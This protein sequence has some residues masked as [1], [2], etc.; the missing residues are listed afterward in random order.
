MKKQILCSAMIALLIGSTSTSVGSIF[1]NAD[2][3]ATTKIETTKQAIVDDELST[4][5]TLSKPIFNIDQSTYL[6]AVKYDWY[7]VGGDRV[8][9]SRYTN[10]N[11]AEMGNSPHY[12]EYQFPFQSAHDSATLCVP[13]DYYYKS[14][15]TATKTMSYSYSTSEHTATVTDKNGN[16]YTA[17][18][19]G[20]DCQL[21][22]VYS[23]EEFALHGTIPT[24]FDE[25]HYVWYHRANKNYKV[26]ATLRYKDKC[27]NMKVTIPSI[28]LR[29]SNVYIDDVKFSIRSG[30]N[31]CS[32][33]CDKENVR[34]FNF[35]FGVLQNDSPLLSSITFNGD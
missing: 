7:S 9:G 4:Y 25:D 26:V 29:T 13:R 24:S 12:T 17:T 6:F 19:Y 33:K 16:T 5:A 34:D 27:V 21:T 11:F 14:Y 22:P 30:P 35:A 3:N 10:Q 18:V 8:M 2:A 20:Y 28:G 32:L 31:R 23:F 1:A 15:D